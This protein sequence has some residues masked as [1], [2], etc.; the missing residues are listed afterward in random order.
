MQLSCPCHSAFSRVSHVSLLLRDQH[1]L[2]HHEVVLDLD[3]EEYSKQIKAVIWLAR[4]RYLVLAYEYIKVDL[5]LLVELY[6]SFA[7]FS[8]LCYNKGSLRAV[9]SSTYRE[10]EVV[11]L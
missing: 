3:L 11:C 5:Y 2:E 4:K 1:H 8:R 6:Y 9:E 10:V 7:V